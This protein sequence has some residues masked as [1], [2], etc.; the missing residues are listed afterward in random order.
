MF[1]TKMYNWIYCGLKYEGF[2]NY[3]ANEFIASVAAGFTLS[4][5]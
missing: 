3:R 5:P 4:F 1:I 2:P